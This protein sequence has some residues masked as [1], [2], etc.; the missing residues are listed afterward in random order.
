VSGD[1]FVYATSD[2]RPRRSRARWV[3]VSVAF[4]LGLAALAVRAVH[5]PTRHSPHPPRHATARPTYG[6]AVRAAVDAL[7]GLTVPALL[8]RRAF[9][10]AVSRYGAPE[11][12]PRIR[13]TFGA[14][15][16]R[17]LAAFAERPRVLRGAPVG[18]RIERFTRRSA[19]VAVWTVAIAATKRFG[20]RVAWRTLTIDL[21]WMAGRWRVTGGAGRNGPVPSAPLARFAAASARFNP[22][23]DAR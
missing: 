22:L 8:D 5:E 11:A 4:L 20:V 10:T 12:A 18:Y 1:S 14:A 15:D 6:S 19:S 23:S 7:E 3:V 9:E 16:P 13:A 17:L 21:V 2:G